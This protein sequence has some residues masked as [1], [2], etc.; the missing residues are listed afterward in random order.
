MININRALGTLF[1]VAACCLVPLSLVFAFQITEVMFDPEGVDAKREWVEVY[2]NTSLSI[3]LS[4]YYFLENNVYHGISENPVSSIVGPGQYAIIASDATTFILEYPNVSRVFDSVFSLNN[5]GELIAIANENK[6]T[7]SSLFYDPTIGAKGDGNSLSLVGTTWQARKPSPG[8]VASVEIINDSGDV[9][10][11]KKPTLKPQLSNEVT[12]APGST[13]V[14]VPE[15]AVTDQVV[16]FEIINKEKNTRVTWSLG[17]G[18]VGSGTSIIHRYILPGT[19]SV[20]AKIETRDEDDYEFFG[21][22]II[23]SPLVQISTGYHNEQ[24]YLRLTNKNL[25]NLDISKWSVVISGKRYQLPDNLLITPNNDYA[26]TIG[27]S[28]SYPIFVQDSRHQVVAKVL[29]PKSTPL[30][31]TNIGSVN[32]VNGPSQNPSI[33]IAPDS[34]QTISLENVDMSQL[35]QDALRQQFESYGNIIQNYNPEEVSRFANNQTAAG[36]V[37]F[38]QSEFSNQIGKPSEKIGSSLFLG[39]LVF[40]VGLIFYFFDELKNLLQLALLGKAVQNKKD[41]SQDST[42][43]SEYE[44]IEVEDE[45]F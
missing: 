41:N 40:L 36:L 37:G 23:Q 26:F 33:F 2:N 3:D 43:N 8:A 1:A 32:A 10:T 39:L 42:D 5:T 27:N 30:S 11:A 21:S 44:I 20:R 9:S 16:K 17:D 7:I 29:I 13:K 45:D 18:T 6:E 15:Y 25:S 38:N 4:N 34:G 31:E 28:F 14:L 35:R 12:I 19:Y 24:R 22:I